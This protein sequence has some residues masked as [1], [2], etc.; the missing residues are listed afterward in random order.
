MVIDKGKIMIIAAVAGFILVLVLLFLPGSKEEDEGKQENAY[1]EVP[2]ANTEEVSDSKA[3]AYT[4]N[5]NS[6]A[7][8]Y[9]SESE[10]LEEVHK[11]DSKVTS[12]DLFGKG[13]SSSATSVSRSAP[14]S[15]PYR[16]SHQEREERHRRRQ[17]EAIELA[18][19]MTTPE[20]E[21]VPE[22]I[23]ET[24]DIPKE[25]HTVISR[26]TSAI[27]SLDMTDD[28]GGVSS[29]DS[30][31]LVFESDESH[32]FRCMFARESRVKNGQRVSIIL[33]EDIVISGTLVPKNT[34][35]MAT[36]KLSGRLELEIE[37]IE[38]GGRILHLGYEAYDVDGSKGIY[39][40][41]VSSAGKSATARGTNIL[42]SNLT[43]RLGQISREVVST[44][45]SI[46]QSA[47]GEVTVNVPAGYE[48]YIVKQK[49]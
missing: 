13:E 16:E 35:L 29:L 1:A 27:S 21:T 39:C 26:K 24:E 18:E 30:E 4:N 28:S 3:E 11:Q 25:N 37:N 40:P 38:M 46:A 22:V 2:Q 5:R 20:E 15:N 44:G 32:P 47:S 48:F 19:R 8:V 31:D 9:W 14:T 17:E 34:H 12:E 43:R 42:G 36:C 23:E 41:D 33:L 7:R 6:A 45:I 49:K 10:D